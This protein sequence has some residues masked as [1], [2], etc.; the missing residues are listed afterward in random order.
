MVG[1]GA[2]SI[3]ARGIVRRRGIAR[4]SDARPYGYCIVA[5][6][7]R[8]PPTPRGS[9]RVYFGPEGVNVGRGKKSVK[10]NAAL[11]HFLGFFS[12]TL[13]FGVLRGEQPLGRAAVR[14]RSDQ[15]PS[16]ALKHTS[17]PALRDG[18]HRFGRQARAIGSSGH[19]FRFLFGCPKRKDYRQK[20]AIKG[21]HRK[22]VT[23]VTQ[24]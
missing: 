24:A 14:S 3:S 6:R 10:K 15:S 18:G 21:C 11:L 4:A 9:H 13:L 2:D 17:G 5:C 23:P 7:G 16:G 22:V 8:R 1:V 19:L 20:D 12:L